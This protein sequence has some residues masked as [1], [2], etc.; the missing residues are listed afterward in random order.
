MPKLKFKKFLFTAISICSYSFSM[1]AHTPNLF[2]LNEN[3]FF[4]WAKHVFNFL[5]DYLWLWNLQPE[6]ILSD[7]TTRKT[8]LKIED[9]KECNYGTL[10]TMI[11]AASSPWF[12]LLKTELKLFSCLDITRENKSLEKKGGD[13]NRHQFLQEWGYLT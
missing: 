3:R 8:R 11:C 7:P 1:L 10:L 4:H 12:C 13:Q 9:C 2:Q 6:A 5:I